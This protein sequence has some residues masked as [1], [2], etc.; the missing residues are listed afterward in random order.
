MLTKVFIQLLESPVKPEHPIE[1]ICENLGSS[2]KQKVEIDMLKQQVQTYRQQVEDLKK[3][4]EDVQKKQQ[5]TDK[6]DAVPAVLAEITATSGDSVPDTSKDVVAIAVAEAMIV[7]STVEESVDDTK[8]SPIVVA[9][10]E[11]VAAPKT[12]A[13][14]IAV[15]DV[16]SNAETDTI[17]KTVAATTTTTTTETKEEPIVAD[18]SKEET[19]VTIKTEEASPVAEPKE[20]INN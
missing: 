7:E 18:R 9:E 6:A 19:T 16:P 1:F 12:E 10:P 2:I 11:I 14:E 13:V 8:V 17:D 15:A 3:Q 20:P 4:L 5:I